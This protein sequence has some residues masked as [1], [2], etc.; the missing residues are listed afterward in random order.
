MKKLTLS[1][2]ALLLTISMFAQNTFEGTFTVTYKNE[3][4]ETVVAEI[5]AKGDN[6]RVKQTKNGNKKYDYFLVNLKTRDFYTIAAGENKIA[7]KYNLDKILEFYET[8]KLKPGYIRNTNIGLKGTDKTKEE[9]GIKLTQVV[10]DNA[11][12]SATAWTSETAAPIN[13]LIPLLRVLGNWN[14]AQGT[15]QNIVSADV[16]SK[17]GDKK[18][19]T[20]KVS[21]KKETV[22]ISFDVPKD[23]QVKD[24]A[25]LME[26]QKSNKDINIIIQSFAQF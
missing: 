15:T 6:I 1:I 11:K 7:I 17:E 19:T 22:S 4:D 2:F 8:N 26:D 18:T 12:L 24:F 25:A 14:E 10:V 5:Q 9:G 3:K 23:Y 16:T 13:Q 20:V 21:V